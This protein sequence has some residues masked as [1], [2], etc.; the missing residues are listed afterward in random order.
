M[1]VVSDGTSQD[2]GDHPLYQKFKNL[3][4]TFNRCV[5]ANSRAPESERLG[6]FDFVIDCQ[7]EKD[8]RGEG[9]KRV[10]KIKEKAMKE[11]QTN[12]IIW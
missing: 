7:L 11:I 8:L 4:Q 9:D 5:L 10:L 12:S 1:I 2:F 6:P 3:Q